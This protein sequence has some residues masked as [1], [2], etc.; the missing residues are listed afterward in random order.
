MAWTEVLSYR[1]GAVVNS[2]NKYVFGYL[3]EGQLLVLLSDT[4]R[5]ILFRGIG[6]LRKL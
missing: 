6:S 3:R 2:V 5:A 4:S 1:M